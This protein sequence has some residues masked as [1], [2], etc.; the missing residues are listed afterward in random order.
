MNGPAQGLSK[1]KVGIDVPWVTSWT[2]EA[3]QGVAPCPTVDGRVA[4]WQQERAGFG[5]PQYS[6]NHYRRQRASIRGLLCPM[7]GDPAPEGDRWML[8]GKL[9]TAGV[10]RRL[11]VGHTVP[12]DIADD[13]VVLNAGSVSPGHLDCMTRSQEQCPHLSSDAEAELRPFPAL[14]YVSL[15]QVPA[16]VGLKGQGMLALA[17]APP[18]DMPVV[19]FLQLCGVTDEVDR[20]WRLRLRQPNPLGL[21]VAP[22]LPIPQSLPIV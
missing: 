12:P 18:P 14:W 17:S 4:I 5:K 22:G 13:R 6:M 10:A 15:L 9:G 8:T 21:P 3:V 16:S 11:G 7:C 20:K 1:L 2:A 19:A